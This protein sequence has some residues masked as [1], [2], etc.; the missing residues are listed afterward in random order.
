MNP[1]LLPP[2]LVVALLLSACDYQ[3]LTLDQDA[4]RM[5]PKLGVES[6]R[7]QFLSY[8]D[9]QAR[10]EHKNRKVTAFRGTVA[11]TESDLRLLTRHKKH[12]F[13]KD[14]VSI[15]IREMNGVCVVNS[16]VHIKHADEEIILDFEAY[17]SKDFAASD[18]FELVQRL[19]RLG[20]SPYTG[21]EMA[22]FKQKRG[23]RMV[24]N[25]SYFGELRD[26]KVGSEASLNGDGSYRSS[27][28]DHVDVDSVD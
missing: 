17:S 5:A 24:R 27:Y 13:S 26:H 10:I 22:E 2:L 12:L 15:P 4:D 19:A 14:V 23:G 1:R 7:I 8:S 3:E 20:V 21:A 28:Y 16:Q 25:N 9:F 11:L 6:S 18:T